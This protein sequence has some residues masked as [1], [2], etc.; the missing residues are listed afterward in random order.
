M[1]SATFWGLCMAVPVADADA[2]STRFVPARFGDDNPLARIDITPRDLTRRKSDVDIECQTFVERDGALTDYYC[3][4]PNISEDQKVTQLVVRALEEM[5]FEPAQVDDSPVRVLMNFSVSIQ[6]GEDRCIVDGVPNH[7]NHSEALGDDY[8][9]PQPILPGPGWYDGYQDKLDWIHGWMPN[10]SF[11]FNQLGW[12]IRPTVAVDVD[13]DGMG[14]TGC[15]WSLRLTGDDE[16][17]HNRQKLE[18]ALQSMGTTRFVPGFHDGH[19]VSMTFYEHTVFRN[20]AQLVSRPPRNHQFVRFS[21]R[22]FS[23]ALANR[24]E[25]PELYCAG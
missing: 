15:I 25:A 17:Q 11:R 24:S 6:C 12:P 23:Q 10:L 2:Q 8:V 7:G 21:N 22:Y 1:F 14:T 19:P 4:P 5:R 16:E 9:A 18:S 20:A 3:V 13:S